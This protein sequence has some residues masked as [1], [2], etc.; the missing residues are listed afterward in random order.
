MIDLVD[1]WMDQKEIRTDG[2]KGVSGLQDFIGILGYEDFES[3][4]R[5]NQGC[6]ENIYEWVKA[7][8]VPEWKENLQEVVEEDEEEEDDY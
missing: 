2:S 5:D 8:N 4:L 1:S 7:Q 6:V 3:F